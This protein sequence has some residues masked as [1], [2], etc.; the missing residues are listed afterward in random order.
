MRP[1]YPLHSRLFLF[2]NCMLALLWSVT[3]VVFQLC[4]SISKKQ[5]LT[6]MYKYQYPYQITCLFKYFCIYS[7][8]W[9][10]EIIHWFQM[11]VVQNC[12]WT[13]ANYSLHNDSLQIAYTYWVGPMLF[14][15]CNKIYKTEWVRT[16]AILSC[17]ALF[18]KT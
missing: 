1:K 13:T 14:A 10:L 7:V 2:L 6:Y 5:T 17:G 12:V 9:K 3:N 8:A 16:H 15:N 4:P 18:P 11:W